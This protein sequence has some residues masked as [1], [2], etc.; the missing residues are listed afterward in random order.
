M[1]RSPVTETSPPSST[2]TSPSRGQHSDRS[3]QRLGQQPWTVAAAPGLPAQLASDL[4]WGSY[5]TARHQQV[6]DR[7]TAMADLARIW[8]P[9]TASCAPG[10]AQPLLLNSALNTAELLTQLAVWRAAT[11]TPATDLRPTG[12][13]TIG[14]PGAYQDTLDRAARQTHSRHRYEERSWHRL[15]PRTSATTPG[16]PP[17][18][19]V[20]YTSK[21]PGNPST[22]TSDEPSAPALTTQLAPLAPSTTLPSARTIDRCR[23]ST[24]RQRCGGGSSLTPAPPRRPPALV[25][26][27]KP[28]EG[29]TT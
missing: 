9:A 21:T 20:S 23:T 8:T 6:R 22:T 26:Q 27:A 13:A 2:P 18:M 14:T 15:L 28:L 16:P 10:G 17:S 4:D 29:P 25:S 19:T 7:A 12:E 24:L 5:L 3:H 1:G 11:N